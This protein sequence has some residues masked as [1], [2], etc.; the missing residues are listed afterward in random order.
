MFVNQK[1]VR[2][3]WVNMVTHDASKSIFHTIKPLNEVVEW[4]RDHRNLKP[5]QSDAEYWELQNKSKLIKIGSQKAEIA[6][7][8]GEIW[9]NIYQI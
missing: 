7:R 4:Y 5:K 8:V 2:N 3:L 9:R 1:M 6:L